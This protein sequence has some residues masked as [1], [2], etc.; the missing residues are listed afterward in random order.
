M[1]EQNPSFPQPTHPTSPN[2]GTAKGAAGVGCTVLALPFF[3]LLILL[4]I[5]L[6]L[7]IPGSIVAAVLLAMAQHGEGPLRHY[8]WVHGTIWQVYGGPA[9][10]FGGSIYGVLQIWDNWFG[11]PAKTQQDADHRREED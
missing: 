11:K 2:P 8:G 7:A 6:V 10:V 1:G 9:V 3:I 5:A 4:G